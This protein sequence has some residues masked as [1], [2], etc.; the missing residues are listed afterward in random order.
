MTTTF[1]AVNID[2]I[3]PIELDAEGFGSTE[4]STVMKEFEKTVLQYGALPAMFYKPV[5]NVRS[6]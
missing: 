4:A 5:V 3:L 6:L 1:R 2:D